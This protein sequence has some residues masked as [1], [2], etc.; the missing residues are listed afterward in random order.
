MRPA[1]P[2]PL[3]SA[4]DRARSESLQTSVGAIQTQVALSAGAGA[5]EMA[6]IFPGASKEVI[7]AVQM[8]QMTLSY[9]QLAETVRRDAL[10]KGFL[11]RQMTNV[12]GFPTRLI[13][14]GFYDMYDLSVVKPM[15]MATDVYQQ[16]SHGE[17][18][19]LKDAWYRSGIG[20]AGEVGA[21]VGSGQSL[22]R[23][24]AHGFGTGYVAGMADPFERPGVATEFDR[25]LNE[26]LSM[27]EAVEGAMK[28]GDDRY[29]RDIMKRAWDQADS[30]TMKV[31]VNGV[32]YRQ[33]ISPGRLAA[34][35]AY[36]ME[37]ITPGTLPAV[38]FTGAVDAGFQIW[39]DP[40]DPGINQVTRMGSRFKK[41]R[42]NSAG[43]VDEMIDAVGG[44]PIQRN[45]GVRMNTPD[46]LV[47]DMGNV[48]QG[49]VGDDPS[50]PVKARSVEGKAFHGTDAENLVD[51]GIY[52]GGVTGDLDEAIRTA[53]ARTEPGEQAYVY[54]MDTPNLP[55]NVQTTLL[56][57]GKVEQYVTTRRLEIDELEKVDEFVG[58]IQQARRYSED[59]QRDYDELD[60]HLRDTSPEYEASIDE[61]QAW[62]AAG[63]PL[64][65]DSPPTPAEA[66]RIFLEVDEVR[67]QDKLAR[68]IENAEQ[69]TEDLL[70][71]LHFEDPEIRA[72]AGRDLG[73]DYGNELQSSSFPLE[74]AVRLR[75]EDAEE[76]IEKGYLFDSPE[77]MGA[78][79]KYTDE[80]LQ[81]AQSRGVW[82]AK[83]PQE[84]LGSRKGRRLLQWVMNPDVP[85][86]K[87]LDLFVGAGVPVED[88]FGVK[89]A[90]DDPVNGA[91]AMGINI[92][93]WINQRRLVNQIDAP[94]GYRMMGGSGGVYGAIIPGSATK[95]G[96]N[97]GLSPPR[98]AFSNWGRRWAA[99]SSKSA[100]DPWDYQTSFDTIV[101]IGYTM[102]FDD[103]VIDELVL[104]A[105]TQQ[106]SYKG[107]QAVEAKL[108]EHVSEA[109]KRPTRGIPPLKYEAEIIDRMMKTYMEE[110][111]RTTLFL[112]DQAARPL[113][114]KDTHIVM[115]RLPGGETLSIPM[116]GPILD[117]QLAMTHIHVPSTREL[118][119]VSAPTR[120][121]IHKMKEHPLEFSRTHMDRLIDGTVAVWRNGQLAR[122]GWI[123][124]VHPDEWARLF[125][126][127]HGDV[128]GNA[129]FALLTFT[130]KAGNELSMGRALDEI[131][132]LEGGLGTGAFP[133]DINDNPLLRGHVSEEVVNWTMV[134]S[135]LL[136]NTGV[137]IGV[138]DAGADAIARNWVELYQS[139]LF[140]AFA[141][142]DFNMEQTIYY[143][144]ETDAG[145][146]IVA[147]ILAG[148]GTSKG[149]MPG[150]ATPMSRMGR[151]RAKDPRFP[152]VGEKEA[153]RSEDEAIQ[154]VVERIEV[155][156][157][158]ATGGDWL[159]K[160]PDGKITNMAG[161]PVD[162]FTGMSSRGRAYSKAW[163]VDHLLEWNKT[164]GTPLVAN[165]L[166]SLTL[167]QLRAQWMQT[168]GV[169]YDLRNWPAGKEFWIWKPGDADNARLIANG[170]PEAEK[171]SPRAAREQAV[172][173]VIQEKDLLPAD[174][175]YIVVERADWEAAGEARLPRKVDPEMVEGR[176]AAQQLSEET[177][178]QKARWGYLVDNPEEAA[179]VLDR[180]SRAGVRTEASVVEFEGRPLNQIEYARQLK[181]HENQIE[182]LRSPE[183]EQFAGEQ[184]AGHEERVAALKRARKEGRVVSGP[185]AE[186]VPVADTAEAAIDVRTLSVQQWNDLDENAWIEVYHVTN[187]ETAERFATRGIEGRKKN[188]RVG[189]DVRLERGQA[190]EGLYVGGDPSKLQFYIP[191]ESDEVAA[192]VRVRVRKKDVLI[193]DEYAGQGQPTIHTLMAGRTGGAVFGD[194]PPE[195][196]RIIGEGVTSPDPI[197]GQGVFGEPVSSVELDQLGPDPIPRLHDVVQGR[198]QEILDDLAYQMERDMDSWAWYDKQTTASLERPGERLT[199]T[200]KA[201]KQEGRLS[202]EI[203][204]GDQV[205]VVVDQ[206]GMDPQAELDMWTGGDGVEFQFDPDRMS[207]VSVEELEGRAARL[208]AESD[209]PLL[210]NDMDADGFRN[211]R[212]YVQNQAFDF[213]KDGHIP[214]PRV[215]A[216]VTRLPEE[217]MG[218]RAIDKIF[219]VLGQ[220]PSNVIRNPYSRI[221]MW[222][223]MAEHYLYATDDVKAAIRAQAA[224]T[225]ITSKDFDRFVAK[226]MKQHGLDDVP[227]PAALPL[228]YDE[229]E[230][231]AMST[232][233]GDTRDLFFDLSKRGNWAD[234][235]KVF[236]TFGDAW[237]EVLTR[238]GRLMN[239]ALAREAGQPFRN[240][241]RLQSAT[242]GAQRSGW[243][244]TNER[245]QRVFRW[246]PGAAM[247][248]AI[249]QL[250]DNF[251]I[252][253]QVSMNQLMFVDFSDPRSLMGPGASIGI[254]VLAS[255]LR[256]KFDGLMGDVVDFV[257]FGTR[258]PVETDAVGMMNLIFPTWFNKVFRAMNR[259]EYDEQYASLTLNIANGL[260]ASNDPKY[261][262]FTTDA[263][264][265]QRLLDDS[266]RIAGT[267]IWVDAIASAFTPAQPRAIVE[268]LRTDADGAEVAFQLQAIATDLAYFRKHFDDDEAL[269][270][271]MNF[272]GPDPLAIAPK[273][274]GVFSRP[275]T[276]LAYDTYQEHPKLLELLPRIAAGFL[277]PEDNAEFYVPEHQRQIDAG[278]RAKLTV[279]QGLGLVGHTLGAQQMRNLSVE[280]EDAK[281]I[282]QL[283]YGHDS[284]EY[285]MWIEVNTKKYNAAKWSI[286]TMYYGWNAG[287]GPTGVPQRPTFKTVANEMI[288][289]GTPGDPAHTVALEVDPQ[290]TVVLEQVARVWNE[291]DQRSIQAGFEHDWWNRS[292]STAD[293][294]TARMRADFER[295]VQNIAVGIT[296]PETQEKFQWFADFVITPLM[297]DRSPDDPF[298]VTYEPF[299]EGGS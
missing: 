207:V 264:A 32:E 228:S 169:P 21:A 229:I 277:T 289:A 284:D 127:G 120:K 14:A 116:D 227:P 28:W 10:T 248:T 56:N 38:M 31:T 189:G 65:N 117:S 210:F 219:E 142:N 105:W 196:V 233:I 154:A 242:M 47:D 234:A 182:Y 287:D 136:S 77:A 48:G 222:E 187:Q 259:G 67:R 290:L 152:T 33:G 13:T 256:P 11:E 34:M 190:G 63:R 1:T 140:H 45:N 126:E 78:A 253:N 235:S 20:A 26:G 181:H 61:Y 224:R 123:M 268:L 201:Y 39:L 183:G 62:D 240:L 246:F 292:D 285:R 139:D 200:G 209:V 101:T 226:A 184:L 128:L 254:Q 36:W 17:D 203:D 239:P 299:L 251:S 195:N 144:R 172:H 138:N 170:T 266:N 159:H 132:K 24:L 160:A 166:K 204:G 83:N 198:G 68:E 121:L 276:R 95:I 125:A 156:T 173:R 155:M 147:D 60:A 86:H 217:K 192:T 168:I 122:P 220:K 215:K 293:F 143:L 15:R 164:M 249:H 244:E 111:R 269:Q 76:M 267:Y 211:L 3:Q 185:G 130:N 54:V 216:P 146:K 208:A 25:L 286:E 245:N 2:D 84:F 260:Y 158:E 93:R 50:P 100:L 92:E 133:R 58:E 29:G 30:V 175:T 135:H 80:E 283:Q 141:A 88:V 66:R 115:R 241:R 18:I 163:F 258:N 273:S 250:P 9:P 71:Q 298:I 37:I 230:Q 148:E 180:A 43:S 270:M 12:L 46:D 194:V 218:R 202:S 280:W 82:T 96:G 279:K 27:E 104:M 162:D 129:W 261:A 57:D 114:G 108:M 206:K 193:P 99:T 8:S 161:D 110:Q 124:S 294:T 151:T 213:R 42:P 297:V 118:R 109:L 174:T 149:R 112:V 22:P 191:P 73:L 131:A 225:Q 134:D 41:L 265:Q 97:V 6:R 103:A 252:T 288:S 87:K 52:S 69:G 197:P 16:A 247:A 81:L 176:T 262:G 98:R 274:Y 40:S 295:T 281:A 177:I 107:Y 231:V 145:R 255:A 137:P 53:R 186:T 44:R 85:W 35:P 153:I 232:A 205:V 5:D 119:R 272:Y 178:V 275:S 212:D 72:Q 171:L 64:D 236:F 23:T 278:D 214:P 19:S 188:F 271:V 59:L 243:F 221:R 90:I 106:K 51:D 291:F 199:T 150:E 282:K 237:W 113:A 238:W 263:A 75:V 74:P 157:A 55:D 257:A 49:L 91:Q 4:Q 165:Q 296:S 79:Y 70:E 7:A 94:L 179:L 89:F 167:D 223:V 102:G